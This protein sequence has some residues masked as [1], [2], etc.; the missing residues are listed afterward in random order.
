MVGRSR[1]GMGLCDGA[2]FVGPA[3]RDRA[4][5][6]GAGWFVWRRTHHDPVRCVLFLLLTF[7]ATTATVHPWYVA[8]VVPLLAVRFHRAVVLFTLTILAAH[9]VK[10]DSLLTGV[11]HEPRWLGPVVWLPPCLL[12]AV[13][14]WRAGSA[15]RQGHAS[16]PVR[17]QR[18][19]THVEE[20]AGKDQQEH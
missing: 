16:E 3:N 2:Q 15:R 4:V 7:L 6:R 19:K 11:W 12:G 8:W 17:P 14:L 13:D 9:W 10:A 1:Q 5:P 18:S 20:S